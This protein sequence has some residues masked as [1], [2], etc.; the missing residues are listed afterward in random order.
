M[1]RQASSTLKVSFGPK[2]LIHRALAEPGVRFQLSQPWLTRWNGAKRR[3]ERLDSIRPS[4]EAII[5]FVVESVARSC[6]Y[7]A[8][9]SIHHE[10]SGRSSL[11][12]SHV[13]LF[14]DILGMPAVLGL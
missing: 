14:D 11:V 1:F 4:R 3:F 2:I 8:V 9:I 7:D 13:D 5:N 12:E 10:S 6:R